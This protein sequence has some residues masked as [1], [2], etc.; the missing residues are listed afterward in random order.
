MDYQELEGMTVVKL[1]DEAKK[2]EDIKGT[3]GMKKEEL[4][5]ILA[6]K[7]GLE[8]PISKPKKKKAGK[9][10]SKDAIKSKIAELRESRD[11]ARA[12]K[13]NKQ[14]DALR[15]RIH[16]LKRRLSKAA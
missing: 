15:R 4:I 14:V 7:L 16:L 8:K 1:R 5:A 13:D 11:A 2:F 3:A 9:A 12:S 6:E 10:L